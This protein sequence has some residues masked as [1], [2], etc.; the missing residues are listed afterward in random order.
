ML[1]VGRERLE[2]NF[3]AFFNLRDDKGQELGDDLHCDPLGSPG[4][5]LVGLHRESMESNFETSHVARFKNWR[6][7]SHDSCTWSLRKLSDLQ[8]L[9]LNNMSFRDFPL[10]YDM[11]GRPLKIFLCRCSFCVHVRCHFPISVFFGLGKAGWYV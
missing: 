1:G 8:S 11:R 6:R 3:I 4:T 2:G 7:A 10:R 9:A 5:V